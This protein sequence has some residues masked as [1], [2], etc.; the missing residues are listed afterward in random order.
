MKKILFIAISLLVFKSNLKAQ[1]S[2]DTCQYIHR[3]N[4]EWMYASGSDTIRIFLRVQRDYY[5]DF[6]AVEDVI[7]GWHEYKQGNTI[8]EST[9]PNRFMT[10]SN[11]D[12]I[13]KT[14]FSIGLKSLGLH[15]NAGVMTASGSINDY[16]NGNQAK[17][18]VATLDATGTII[19]WKQWHAAS[20]G[21]FG[22]P[23]GMTLPADFTLIKQ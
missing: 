9:Y 11:V 13:T 19:T 20:N 2:F 17:M 7:Y 18:V 22:R 5:T 16:L 15:C 23:S 1:T 21:M 3:F 10:I 12:T 14:S 8:I 6:K 4:G